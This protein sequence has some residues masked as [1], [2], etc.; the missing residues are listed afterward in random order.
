MLAIV[1]L[2]ESF[3][4]ASILDDMTN[5]DSN[6]ETESHGQGVSNIVAGL[7]GGMAGYA[8]IGQSIVN[9]KAGARGRFSTFIAGITLIILILIF[10]DWV[11]Q[12]P[13]PV[14]A[15]VMIVVCITQFD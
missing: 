7:F 12:I 8:M 13:M 3:L 11:K 10:G 15:G 1:G 5:K 9:V 2:L 4:T 6:K 14:L